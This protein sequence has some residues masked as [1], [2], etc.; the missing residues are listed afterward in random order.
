MTLFSLLEDKIMQH[1]RKQVL[2]YRQHPH[3]CVPADTSL[4][5]DDPLSGPTQCLK[6]NCCFAFPKSVKTQNCAEWIHKTSVMWT[7]AEWDVVL[8]EWF[9]VTGNTSSWRVSMK[10]A[11]VA[12]FKMNNPSIMQAGIKTNQSVGFILPGRSTNTTQTFMFTSV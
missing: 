12:W 7:Q 10:F 9:R 2:K 4:K 8:A 5:S 6:S 1:I 11:D 3:T